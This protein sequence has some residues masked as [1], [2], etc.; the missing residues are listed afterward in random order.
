MTFWQEFWG[1]PIILWLQ[2]LG[3]VLTP[4]MRAVTFLGN[5]EFYLLMMPA[6]LWCLHAGLGLRIGFILL[7]S[8]S[9]N[10]IFKLLFGLPRPFWA[11]AKVEALA[12]GSTFGLP[13][14]HA[15]NAMAIWGRAAAWVRNTPARA[16][17]TA[18][19]FLIGL[20]R[21]YLGVHFPSDVLAGWFVG[22]LILI[23]FLRLERVVIERLRRS[24][25]LGQILAA[26]FASLLLL[27]IGLSVYSTTAGRAVPQ[28]WADR[29]SQAFPDEPS[30]D[31]QDLG[32]I[33]SSSGTL[34]G[35][36]VGA[37]LLLSWGGFHAGGPW[38]KRALRYFLGAAGIAAIYYGLKLVFPSGEAFLPQALRYV[39]Y[40]LV[41]FWAS[42]LAPRLFVALRLA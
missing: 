25:V 34:L 24:E 18:L 27:G 7:T 13:S 23:G 29:A 10:G 15:Q 26:G 2:G 36:G 4:I 22:G 16:V 8:S 40:A 32:D 1:I 42:Y 20:S 6:I 19:I 33:V 12:E 37:A 5:E 35:V 28:S 31:P 3:G 30:I 41:G 9:L 17:L 11:S 38:G 14:G 21:I 39:R